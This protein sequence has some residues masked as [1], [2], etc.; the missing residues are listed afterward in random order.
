M[1]V[2]MLK[3]YELNL[4]PEEEKQ[5]ERLRELLGA[6]SIQEAVL[7]AAHVLFALQERNQAD[8]LIKSDQDSLPQP[9]QEFTHGNHPFASLMGR[10]RGDMWEEIMAD[11]E[12]DRQM[13]DRG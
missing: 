6:K 8:L 10:Y 3:Q 13:G 9:G 1:S 7:R 12:Q 2:F 11:L 5:L 4:T